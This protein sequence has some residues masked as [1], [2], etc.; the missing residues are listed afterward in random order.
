MINNISMKNKIKIIINI[1]QTLTKKY[2]IRVLAS[3]ITY[4]L[5]IIILP[6]IILIDTLVNKIW[7]GFGL[8]SLLF[9]INLIWCTSSLFLTLKQT[10]DIVY[11][12][13]DKRSYLKSR[14]LSFINCFF[15]II[16]IIILISFN[17]FINFSKYYLLG[18][19]IEFVS[20]WLI[21]AFIYKKIIPIYIKYQKVLITSMI[22]TIIWYILS[23]VF[24]NIIKSFLIVNYGKIYNNFAGAF[25]FIYYLYL[26]SY[27]FIGGI[28]Y[29]YYLY[30]LSI[31][32]K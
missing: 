31:K 1:Y 32:N 7:L 5:I 3:S 10:S 21:T 25:I 8:S 6:L 30:Q 17:L 12:D 14:V 23:F 20:I 18:I 15:V 29:Q 27:V 13:I 4:N 26:L 11:E 22:I 2:S 28:I 19:L 9:I 16:F 24:V